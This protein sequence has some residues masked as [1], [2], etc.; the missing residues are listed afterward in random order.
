M[1]T[2]RDFENFKSL[3]QIYYPFKEDVDDA[4]RSIDNVRKATEYLET[5]H[6]QLRVM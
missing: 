4:L 2:D 6:L 3:A 1:I 5:Y